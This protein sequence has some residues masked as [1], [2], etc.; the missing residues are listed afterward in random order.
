MDNRGP[1][2]VAGMR[3]QVGV[4]RDGAE[5]IDWTA[6][7]DE[8]DWARARRHALDELHALI[9]AEDCCQEYRL[10]V[11]SVPAIVFPGINDDGTLDLA[12]VNDVL[13]ADRYG[14]TATT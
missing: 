4:L 9:A 13:A 12:H 2:I 7:G 8:P 1:V 3:W 5:N 10:L 6:A 11:D 14:E